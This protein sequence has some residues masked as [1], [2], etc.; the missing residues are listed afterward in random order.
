MGVAK[1]SPLGACREIVFFQARKAVESLWG[2][3]GIVLVYG[4]NLNPT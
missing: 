1:L 2:G 4:Q 3:T